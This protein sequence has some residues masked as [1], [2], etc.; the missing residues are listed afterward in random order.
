MGIRINLS[1]DEALY[2]LLEEDANQHNCTVNGYLNTMLEQIYK[3]NP[4]DYPAAL[5]ALE[6]EAK[7]QPLGKDFT[8]VDLP[9]FS[10]ICIVRAEEAKLKPSIVRARLGKLFN[11]RVRAKAVGDV[12][13]SRK[14]NGELKF[15][16][17]A[18]VYC[19]GA[20]DVEK[21][22]KLNRKYRANE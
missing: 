14:D 15:I 13:R 11:A 17:R 10:E 16:S 20:V 19:R 3:Q 1:L 21:A 9:S 4:F 22:K 5:E 6:K 2:K 7:E 18:A 8:L 12:G